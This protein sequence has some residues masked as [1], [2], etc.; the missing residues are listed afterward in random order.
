MISSASSIPMQSSSSVT[1]PVW[2]ATWTCACRSLK[3]R[4]GS[5]SASISWMRPGENGSASISPCF[6]HCSGSLSW[7]RQRAAAKAW[8]GSLPR[9][10]GKSAQ[11]RFTMS[12]TGSFTRNLWKKPCRSSSHWHPSSAGAGPV[13]AGCHCGSWLRMRV[14][15]LPAGSTGMS[16]GMPGPGCRRNFGNS[17][18]N[19]RI[20][21]MTG[22]GSRTPLRKL[23]SVRLKRSAIR[24]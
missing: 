7:G 1:R 24:P 14:S 16:T 5:S 12:L 21:A 19:L 6:P 11:V 20:R 18:G 22:K 4:P 17:G 15:L 23:L 13:P 3:R 9:S 2:S 10:S 8:T